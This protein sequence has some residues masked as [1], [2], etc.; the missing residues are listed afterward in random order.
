[1]ERLKTTIR[2]HRV[3]NQKL[4]QF[5][6]GFD[7]LAE[8]IHLKPKNKWLYAQSFM[9]SSYINDLSLDRIYNNERLEFLGDA[10]LELNVSDYLYQR[11]VELPEGELTKLRANIVCEPSLV[12][13]SEHLNMSRLIMLG[14][15][16]EKT[17]GRERPSII[18]DAFEAFIG[19]MYLDLGNDAVIQFLK[20]YVYIHLTDK[21]YTQQKDFKTEL[22]ERIHQLK[23]GQVTYEMLEESG[24]SHNKTF[25]SGVYVG[26]QLIA[27]GTGSSKKVAEQH[28]AEAALEIITN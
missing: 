14:K 19:A 12:V 7:V 13:F 9:H 17:G 22:Q 25:T 26:E 4:S 28:A 21:N 24:P 5:W 1:M 23:R 27:S 18:S 8:Q 11:Y 20:E 3:A 15:G 16:E 6:Q 10:V 2:E